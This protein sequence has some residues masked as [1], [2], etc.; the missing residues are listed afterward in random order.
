MQEQ[1][2]R[3]SAATTKGCHRR[4]AIIGGLLRE[5]TLQI[6]N[7]KYLAQPNRYKRA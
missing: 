7:L 6:T 2:P 5:T 3:Q 1:L 4:C